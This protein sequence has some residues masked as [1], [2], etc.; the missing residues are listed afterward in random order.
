MMDLFT[1]AAKTDPQHHIL[2]QNVNAA[3]AWFKAGGPGKGLPLDLAVRHDFQ[4]LERTAQ[5]T[6][7]G[8]LIEELDVWSSKYIKTPEHEGST[9]ALAPRKLK[10]MR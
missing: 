4:L 5:P 3:R 2:I 6:L 10:V 9:K 1:T 7:P 8:P